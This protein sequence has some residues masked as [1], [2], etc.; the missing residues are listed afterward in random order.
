ME[1]K[2][3]YKIKKTRA[4]PKPK[5]PV[6]KQ[7]RV[8]SDASLSIETT[9][10]SE[11]P[12][13]VK[14]KLDKREFVTMTQDEFMAEGKSFLVMM[15]LS[16]NFSVRFVVISKRQRILGNIRNR[17][18]L[19]IRHTESASADTQRIRIVPLAITRHVRRK[20]LVIMVSMDFSGL[21]IQLSLQVEKR[22]L[23][24]HLRR[25]RNERISWI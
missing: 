21:V 12:K 13:A 25:V 19:P 11:M 3:E 10:P 22:L 14:P 17:V 20:A 5:K 16:G 18:R 1:E 24:F 7:S 8:T 23:F 15:S 9:E 6:S 4:K 2:V